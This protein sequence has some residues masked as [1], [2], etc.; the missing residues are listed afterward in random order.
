MCTHAARCKRASSVAREHQV[1]MRCTLS[2][3]CR[4]ISCSCELEIKSSW[5]HEDENAF[6]RQGYM[7]AV[8][9]SFHTAVL[10]AM[11]AAN[12]PLRLNGPKN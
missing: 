6:I 4:N 8:I 3:G 1:H 10:R 5:R 12:N 7:T 2:G 9:S 11:P